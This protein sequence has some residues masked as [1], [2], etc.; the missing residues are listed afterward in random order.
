MKRLL[1]FLSIILLF[2]ACDNSQDTNVKSDN[3]AAAPP[4]A[5]ASSFVAAY[6]ASNEAI[7]SDRYLQ[8]SD[9]DQKI[10]RNANLKY[11]VKDMDSSLAMIGELLTTFDAVIQNER[12]RNQG[13]R[14]YSYLTVRVPA[15]DFEN[16]ITNLLEGKG[17]RKIE[18]KNISAK[19]VTEQF[20]DIES[21][22]S[23]KRQALARYRE[24]LQ[25]A[26]TVTDMIT[27]E[28]K[29]R[30]LQE[31]IES[32]EARLKYLNEQ[33]EMSE[34]RIDL[35]ETIKTTYVPEKSNNF[36][37]TLLRA[38]HGGFK[39]IVVVFFWFIR[40][41]P[42]WLGLIMIRLITKKPKKD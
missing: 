5:E 28:D 6:K 31:E 39:G 13:D 41:W 40:L 2:V 23:T 17:I 32:R 35:Y 20:I 37:P 33:I 21:R 7:K 10:V 42:L 36:F 24:L 18:E 12:H 30:R 14:L 4:Q 25:K 15:K 26:E 27:V 3:N 1:I 29:I 16:F 8:N 22:L 11:E 34:I 19:D 9:K 38:L